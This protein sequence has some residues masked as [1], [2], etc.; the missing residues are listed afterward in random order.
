MHSSIADSLDAL[1]SWRAELER[2]VAQMGRS[3]A[4]QEL[5]DGADQALLS[6]LR[7]RLSSDKLVLAF[8]AES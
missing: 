8:V 7:E 1:A 4:E 5:L 3:L 2:H 6:S